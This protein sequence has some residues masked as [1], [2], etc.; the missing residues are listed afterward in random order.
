MEPAD[1]HIL[2]WMLQWSK[3]DFTLFLPLAIP[4]TAGLVLFMRRI[5]K[6]SGQK[7]EP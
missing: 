2:T 1:P 6:T 5:M 3:L 7:S 4:F